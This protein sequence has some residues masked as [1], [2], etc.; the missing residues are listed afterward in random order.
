MDSPPEVYAWTQ[1][2]NS[3]LDQQFFALMDHTDP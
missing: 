1:V 3:A 2:K